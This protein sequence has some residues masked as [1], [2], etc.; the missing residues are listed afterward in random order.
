LGA[1]RAARDR[2]AGRE[3]PRG[4]PPSWPL[5]PVWQ[6]HLAYLEPRTHERNAVWEGGLCVIPAGPN[7]N[8]YLTGVPGHAGLEEIEA[9]YPGA[10]ARLRRHP[11]IGFLLVR[12]PSGP[13]CYY[14]SAVLS[15][16]PPPGPTGCP[17]FDRPD[18]ALVV[19]GLEELLAMPSAG[20]IM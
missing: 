18:R 9:H 8:V 19:K 6:Q 12:G 5:S 11:G 15:V 3:A 4:T 16:P 17:L 20:D 7:L 2:S 13:L 1:V 10:G 14:R